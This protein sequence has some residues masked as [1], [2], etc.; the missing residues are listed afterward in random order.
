MALLD[1]AFTIT[2]S[3][4]YLADL[5]NGNGTKRF[6]ILEPGGL[7]HQYSEPGTYLVRRHSPFLPQ[8][9]KPLDPVYLEVVVAQ[10]SGKLDK[11]FTITR[12]SDNFVVQTVLSSRILEA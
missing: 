1:S 11:T 8:P 12:N 5:W 9:P 4:A 7:S 2:N 3:N 10:A 6:E